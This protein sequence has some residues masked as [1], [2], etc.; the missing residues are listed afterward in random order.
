MFI[1]QQLLTILCILIRSPSALGFRNFEIVESHAAFD[2]PRESL[3]KE[4][5]KEQSAET[6]EHDFED[7]SHETQQVY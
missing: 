4:S 6:S 5:E 1:Q 7:G 3:E 2:A